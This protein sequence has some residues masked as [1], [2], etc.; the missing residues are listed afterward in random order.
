MASTKLV[1]RVLEAQGHGVHG[2][3]P[4]EEAWV[5]VRVASDTTTSNT[6]KTQKRKGHP[7]V[8]NEEYELDIGVGQ[9]EHG[10]GRGQGQGQSLAS[11]HVKLRGKMAGHEGIDDI[12]EGGCEIEKVRDHRSLNLSQV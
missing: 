6:V 4:H 1:V 8:W 11:V 3:F 5:E 12:G 2:M 10:Q 9:A 7:L